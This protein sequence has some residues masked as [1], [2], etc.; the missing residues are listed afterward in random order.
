MIYLIVK[1]ISKLNSRTVPEK[2]AVFLFP[3]P[4]YILPIMWYNMGVV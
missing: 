4:L 3:N 2:G 1:G